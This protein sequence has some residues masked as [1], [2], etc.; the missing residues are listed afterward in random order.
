MKI[1]K[2]STYNTLIKD[3]DSLKIEVINKMG[4]IFELEHEVEKLLKYKTEFYNSKFNFA[5][6]RVIVGK[7]GTGKT[8]FIMNKIA[9]KLK[10]HLIIDF[11]DEYR[12]LNIE[13]YNIHILK[14]DEYKNT[15]EL[16]EKLL[17]VIG[18]NQDK[19][20]ILDNSSF[21]GFSWFQH[22][23]MMNFPYVPYIA[24]CQSKGELDTVR[25][26]L[27]CIYDF[28]TPDKFKYRDGEKPYIIEMPSYRK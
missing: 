6:R 27:D 9:P 8:Y 26:D 15:P 17:E 20:I 22:E 24:V 10:N 25:Y 4:E 23:M 21:V 14:H 12:P 16:R 5:L 19:T 18:N 11:H 7:C 2:N 3:N 13:R 28:G 1:L